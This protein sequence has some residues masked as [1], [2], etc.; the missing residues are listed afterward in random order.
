MISPKSFDHVRARLRNFNFDKFVFGEESECPELDKLVEQLIEDGTVEKDR[1]AAILQFR[2][3]VATSILVARSVYLTEEA[4]SRETAALKERAKLLDRMETTLKQ[5]NSR[6][7]LIPG[8]ESQ[9]HECQRRTEALKRAFDDIRAAYDAIQ[10]QAHNFKNT[11]IFKHTFARNLGCCWEQ[12]TGKPPPK[13]DSGPFANFVQAAF[14]AFAMP[15]ENPGYYA[16]E[17][18][19]RKKIS[20]AT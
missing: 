17:V 13:S 14:R 16:K 20:K 11:D 5:M 7:S 18:F 2:K 12:L 10:L 4:R 15:D 3:A 1:C 9:S 19:S 6:P 8:Q